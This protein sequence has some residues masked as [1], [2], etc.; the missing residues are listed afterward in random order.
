[1]FGERGL[2]RR[3]TQR[4]A[5]KFYKG[6]EKALK[7]KKGLP[8]ASVQETTDGKKGRDRPDAEADRISRSKPAI[9]GGGVSKER[10]FSYRAEGKST[11][12]WKGWHDARRM[13]YVRKKGD[14]YDIGDQR[15]EKEKGRM[16]GREKERPPQ[17]Y[18]SYKKEAS[19]EGEGGDPFFHHRNTSKRKKKIFVYPIGER[20]T[21]RRKGVWSEYQRNDE[22]KPISRYYEDSFDCREGGREKRD[23]DVLKEGTPYIVQGDHDGN[24]RYARESLA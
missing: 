22:R 23:R 13:E 18:L 19:C 16:I 15:K 6:K 11:R 24:Q 12:G 20:E 14:A 17:N 4:P 5:M 1:M 3:K 8:S 2:P 10:E 9:K 7:R 21:V